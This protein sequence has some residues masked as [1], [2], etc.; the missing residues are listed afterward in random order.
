M[1]PEAAAILAAAS[2]R[3]A[4]AIAAVPWLIAA[5]IVLGGTGIGPGGRRSPPC[6]PGCAS[7]S[8]GRD[9]RLPL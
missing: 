8:L 2:L 6:S 9:R 5:G 1:S 7:W 3:R 4:S